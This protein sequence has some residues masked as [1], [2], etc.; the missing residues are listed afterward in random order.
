MHPFFYLKSCRIGGCGFQ[1][2]LLPALLNVRKIASQI[3]LRTKSSHRP[4]MFILELASSIHVKLT[5]EPLENL[6]WNRISSSFRAHKLAAYSR[7]FTM[8]S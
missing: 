8:V 1:L 4:E 2:A 3:L 6:M 5:W 7:A